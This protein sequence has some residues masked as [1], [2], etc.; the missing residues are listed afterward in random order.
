MLTKYA[1]EVYYIWNTY[2]LESII[3]GLAKKV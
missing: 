1:S 3:D 2:I